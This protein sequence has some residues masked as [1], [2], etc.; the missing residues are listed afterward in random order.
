MRLFAF[1][2]VSA[3]LVLLPG[4]SRLEALI[5]QVMPST[6]PA[7]N[8]QPTPPPAPPPAKPAH[9]GKKAE[10]KPEPTQAELFEY[11]R[12]KLIT[13]SPDDGINDNVEVTL[14]SAGTVMTITQPNGR[15][16][17]FL[18]ALNVN[19]I[20]WD[21]FDPSDSHNSRPEMARVTIPS[22]AGKAARA[23][24]DKKGKID[25]DV[26]NNRVRL[27][28]S[29]AKVQMISGFQDKMTKALKKL[30]IDAGGAPEKGLF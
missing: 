23:C 2:G 7:A 25:E 3:I 19:S 20:S 1:L 15:C 24:Y 29:Y 16:D 9:K 26:P 28:F 6:Q 11:I 4:C 22:V 10:P 14:N 13:L 18:S 21:I 8:P 30:I 17:E 5:A 27:L 12:G